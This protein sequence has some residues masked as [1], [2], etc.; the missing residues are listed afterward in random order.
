MRF[1]LNIPNTS[2]TATCAVMTIVAASAWAQHEP[3][4]LS[5][6]PQER[7]TVIAAV[8][9]PLAPSTRALS[10]VSTA[11]SAAKRLAPGSE[12]SR[13]E[14]YIRE[15]HRAL[16]PSEGDLGEVPASF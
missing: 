5:P 13:H 11:P 2:I 12:F 6:K 16:R 4:A 9:I 1:N 7:A 15:R 10:K 14:A 3:T 8:A